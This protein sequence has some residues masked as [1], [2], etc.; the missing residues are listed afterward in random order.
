MASEAPCAAA[1]LAQLPTLRAPH[2]TLLAHPQT[3]IDA[4][5]YPLEA[6]ELATQTAVAI[7]MLVFWMPPVHKTAFNLVL[8]L[9]R[10][11]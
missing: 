2:R 10:L 9:V 3:V 11:S 5:R 1:L 6:G 7:C 4:L 8:R